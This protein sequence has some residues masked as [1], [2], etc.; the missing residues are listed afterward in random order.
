MY[1]KLTLISIAIWGFLL[2]L[3]V[4]YTIRVEYEIIPVIL[5][6]FIFVLIVLKIMYV[7]LRYT[8]L[9]NINK[10]MRKALKNR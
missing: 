6:L 2:G 7:N 10:G 9:E 8:K 1:Y 3:L 5:M 4:E